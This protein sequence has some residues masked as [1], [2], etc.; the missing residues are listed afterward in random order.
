MLRC[1]RDTFAGCW[2]DDATWAIPSKG[3]VVGRDAIVDAFFPP[4]WPAGLGTV[5]EEEEEEEEVVVVAGA[6]GTR[7]ACPLAMCAATTFAAA[8]ASGT[9]AAK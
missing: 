9:V 5:E 3:V 1:D 4:R 7:S 8:T 2:A 6:R